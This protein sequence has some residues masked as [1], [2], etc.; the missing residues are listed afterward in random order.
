[1]DV[2]TIKSPF[3]EQANLK[4]E[5]TRFINKY[6][7]TVK[8]HSKR[9]SDYF[10]MCCFNYVVRFY[11]NSGY[12]IGIQNLQNG[13]YR[14]KCSTAGIQDNFSHFRVSRKDGRIKYTFEIH[15]NLAVQSAH[16]EDI[17]TTPDISVIKLGTV[18]TTVGHYDSKVRFSHVLQ[19]DIITFFEVKHFHPFPELVFNFIGVVNELRPQII[20]NCGKSFKPIHLAPSLMISGKPNKHTSIIKTSLEERYCINIIYDV[21]YTGASTFSK[22]K[23][24]DLRT[25]G[26][27]SRNPSAD[28]FEP[29][30]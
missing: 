6:K 15:H 12:E 8:I 29:P 26:K 11:E 27:I 23:L 7:S 21:F 30:F 16:H 20:K 1:M 13:Q 22:K 4:K 28:L 3:K 19:P 2:P 17:F 9:I 10:E 5:I 14:Y 18:K 25:T 24:T